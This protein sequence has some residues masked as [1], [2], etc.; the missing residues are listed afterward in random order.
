MYVWLLMI[1][2]LVMIR[3]LDIVFI[4]QN[5]VQWEIYLSPLALMRALRCRCTL[6]TNSGWDLEESWMNC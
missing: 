4:F 6:K 5:L 2:S 3:C 1:D